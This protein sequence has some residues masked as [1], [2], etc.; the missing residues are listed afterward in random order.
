MELLDGT[1]W[2]GAVCFFVVGDWATTRYG[3]ARAGVTERNPL[4]RR[5]IARFGPTPSLLV[6]KTAAVAA[7]A[8]GYGYA[9]GDATTRSY[10][11]LFPLVLLVVGV[12]TTVH[13][14]CVL[15]AAG[16]S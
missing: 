9:A 7:A 10:R 8:T 11:L 15:T 14:L 13:N 2:V 16:E 1:L 12:V 5:A 6:L 4:A 3:L